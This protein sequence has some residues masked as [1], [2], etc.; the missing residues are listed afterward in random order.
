MEH[1]CATCGE[2]DI[3][4]RFRLVQTRT[5]TVEGGGG[6]RGGRGGPRINLHFF[7]LHDEPLRLLPLLTGL[8]ELESSRVHAV[9]AVTESTR[10]GRSS[11]Y[12]K[13]ICC[14]SEVP[15]VESILGPIEGV[16]R[17]S[18]N[19]TTKTVYVD[20]DVDVVSV[21]DISSSL[22]TQGFSSAVK[23]DAAVAMEQIAGIPIVILSGV[24]WAVSM[25]SLIGNK[26]EYLKYVALLSVAFGL[27][28]I[29]VKAFSTLRR[30]RFDVNCMM[31][32]AAVGAL[33][34]QEYTEA[35]AVT[36]LF[37]ISEALEARATARARNALSAMVR[38]RPERANVLNPVTK[39]I[40]VLPASA[41]ALGALVSVRTG[42]KIPC[43]GIVVEGTSTVDESSLT[44]ES[45]PVKKSIGMSVSGG[46][47]NSGNCQLLIKT[48]A[49][50]NNSAVARLIRLVEEAQMN[51]SDTEKFVDAFAK[52]YTPVVVLAAFCMVTIPWAF[53]SEV[54]IFWAKNGLITIVIAC[55]CALIIST[56][57]VYVAGLA[58]T[59]QMGVLVKG[60]QYLETLGR[61]KVIAFDKTGCL[62]Q[63]VFAMIHFEVIGQKRPRNEVLGYLAL[64][65]APAS[66]P[67]SDAIVKGAENEQVEVPKLQLR[68]HTLL[69]GEGITA[70]VE[71]T[72]VWVGNKRLFQRL[73]LY[74]GLPEDVKL[75]TEEWAQSGG[76]VGFIS[77][78]GDGIIGA[79]C[80]ADK[81]RDEAEAV[82]RELKRMGI[83]VKMLTGD[84]RPAAIGIGSQ[85]GLEECDI[86]SELL[87]QDKLAEIGVAVK[88]NDMGKRCWRVSRRV[89]MVGACGDGVNDAPALALADVSVAMG[90]GAA[91]AMETAD[92]TLL[93]SNLN[94]LLYILRM[95]RRVI[96]TIVENVAFS[97]IVKALVMGFTFAGKSSLWAAI[98]SDVGAM[99]IVTLNGMKIL[100]RRDLQK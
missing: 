55:P 95:G 50:S 54:G 70:N 20:H 31:L 77:I 9:R 100:P 94:K 67:L 91:L 7:E 24:L 97:L 44:G 81:I 27:P 78:E 23:K 33:P 64:M 48:T 26:W 85:I 38:L 60:G 46:T 18:V 73:D 89:M 28:P 93:D 2:D 5:W 68:N 12:V 4:G 79:Y 25:L 86:I 21:V 14:A 57:V 43:D 30:C 53:G 1:P 99:L 92:I 56:P 90:E 3:H 19:P 40:V 69:P 82:V 39:D 75:K 35:A 6:A 45:R 34:L 16:K 8:F 36:F 80:V 41:V 32:F 96:R 59:A 11:F 58:A 66:H 61:T 49:T 76:T 63:G 10:I 13:D 88:E 71:G 72:D 42:D 62:T 98:A 87:P 84:Q 65:E 22:N 29:A 74:D 52:L 17:V 51:R 83:E 37:A 15:Q 47:I